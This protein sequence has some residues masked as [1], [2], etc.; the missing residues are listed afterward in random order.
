MLGK[1]ELGWSDWWEHA[2]PLPPLPPFPLT[3]T[4][5]VTSQ[6]KKMALYSL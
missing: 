6:H 4:R 1:Q 3:S 5:T 2:S